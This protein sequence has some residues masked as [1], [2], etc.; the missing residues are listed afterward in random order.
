LV[1]GETLAKTGKFAEAAEAFEEALKADPDSPEAFKCLVSARASEAAASKVKETE[2]KRQE[3]VDR[4]VAEGKKALADKQLTV[5]V[6]A[7]ESARQ[8]APTDRAVLQA[9][10]DAQNALEADQ[11]EKGKLAEF[12]KLM[13]AGKAALAAERFPDAVREYTAALVLMPDDLE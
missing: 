8:L 1:Q 6:R 7:L 10:S 11:A 4:L 5:A 2:G 13:D 9:L 3:E 12:R